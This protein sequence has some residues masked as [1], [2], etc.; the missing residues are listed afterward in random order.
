MSAFKA[1]AIERR[2]GRCELPAKLTFGA[3][4]AFSIAAVAAIVGYILYASLPA[5][6]EIGLFAF[7]FGTE[8]IPG[9]NRFGI[10]PMIVG[11]LGA[12]VGALAL[13]GGAGVAAAVFVVYFCPKRLKAAFSQAIKL[14]A[15]IPS[16]VYGFFG[17][18]VLVPWLSGF[19]ADGVGTGLLPVSLILG[20]MIL[21]TVAGV[22][23][24]ALQAVPT[25]F[26]EGAL[27]LGLSK[28]QAVFGTVVP[29]AKSGIL[30]ALVLGAGRAVGETMAIVMIAGNAPQFPEGLLGSFRT[31]TINVV[32]EMGYS[33]G[34]HRSALFA[35]GLVLL[36]LTLAINLILHA[37]KNRKAVGR[38]RA[39]R[40]AVRACGAPSPIYRSRRTASRLLKWL[41]AAVS[42]ILVAILAGI[43][44]FIFVKGL[45]LL[46]PHFLFG[47]PTIADRTLLPAFV[48]TL[49][50]IALTLAIALP[51]GV[52][53]AIFLAE[54]ADKNGKIVKAIRV[55]TDTLAGIPSIVF[56]LFGMMVF[57]EAM[58][59]GQSL[60]AGALTLTLIVLPTVI[61]SCEESLLAVPDALREGAYALGAS[62]TR[63]IFKIVL[64]CALRG[65]LT[66]CVL[67]VGRIVGESAAL[68][69]TAGTSS[70][71]P[72]GYMSS[73]ATFSV[74]MW[75]L[76]S[77]GKETDYVYATAAVLTLIVVAINLTIAL[78]GRKKGN[79][80]K[81]KKLTYKNNRQI[82]V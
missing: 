81:R 57:S 38:S 47:E 35:T 28:E 24:D 73:G 79:H 65:I 25:R 13:G 36:A 33:T 6:E 31:L 50:M 10:L 52:A 14:F 43:L 69:Y 20:L 2:G 42:A 77:K 55:F 58:R 80:E 62:K 66:A 4:A 61:R 68:I 46:T 59:L 71:T 22:A 39:P 56:G 3:A 45:P 9:D 8:W 21:P 78:I 53:A 67:G 16:I 12:T 1:R 15:G 44:L 26:Y 17:M 37:I 18:V 82:S 70:Y 76:M 74:F 34:I 75:V 40:A 72:Q 30:S 5:L 29:A 63:T 23:A 54:Y 64:P 7:L 19:S 41:I 11:T 48:S 32:F 49:M 60:L 51:L 27:A